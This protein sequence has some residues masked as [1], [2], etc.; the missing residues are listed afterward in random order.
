MI[1]ETIESWGEHLNL[2]REQERMAKSGAE[3][4]TTRDAGY[5]K[6]L[7]EIHDRLSAI[8]ADAAPARAARIL[9]G[10]G[11]D[12]EAQGRPLSSFSRLAVSRR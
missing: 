10:L 3:F 8:G 4:I 2:A 9:K 7:K 11:F 5:P 6:L 1:A 12:E